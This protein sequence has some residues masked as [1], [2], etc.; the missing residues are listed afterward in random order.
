MRCVVV[1][2]S[3]SG[4]STFARALARVIEAPYVELDQLHW[5]P[6][7]T[8]RPR[9]EFES[10]VLAATSGERWVIDGN[11]SSMQPL[12]WPL[13][14]HIVWL[15]F[16]RSVVFSRIIRRTLKRTLTRQKL[17]AGNRES[18]VTAFLSK[19]SILLW[20]FTTFDR[21]RARYAELR[22]SPLYSQLQWH[23]LRTPR[24]AQEFLRRHERQTVDA[25]KRRAGAA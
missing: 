25:S 15:N 11:Y 4:K 17:W 16:S 9:E 2:T 19:D 14:T 5:A 7:W 10:A 18:F 22:E 13:A 23:E 20:S 1:G 6:R 21:N 24:Q 8:P 12:F 3:G